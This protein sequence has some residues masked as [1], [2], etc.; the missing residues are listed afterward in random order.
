MTDRNDPAGRISA[1]EAE[2]ADLRETLQ[3]VQSIGLIG[4]VEVDLRRRA[5]RNFRSPEYLVIHGLPPDAA[6]ETHAQW[7][8][9]IHPDDRSRMEN[10]FLTEVSGRE[11]DYSAEYRIIRPSDREVRWI[12]AKGVIE[13]DPAG[14]PIRFVG[15]HLDITERRQLEQQTETIAREF[16]H[17][18][19]NL[20]SVVRSLVAMSARSHPEAAPF[21]EKVIGRIDALFRAKELVQPSR[22]DHT[23]SHTILDLVRTLLAPYAG[24]ENLIAIDGADVPVG[25]RASTALALGL[26]ELATNAVKY[27]ALSRERG[28]LSVVVA[29]LEGHVDVLWSETGGPAL[30]GKP[31]KSGFGFE[32]LDRIFTSQMK[33]TVVHEWLPDGVRVAIR[34]PVDRLAL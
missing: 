30:T 5:F 11:T 31:L 34:L 27:G 6:N 9:R 33:A 14:E 21:A 15:A 26:H 1:L 10:H 19:K 2:N 13:R 28:H 3:R 4:S 18:V 12:F 17:R 16:A 22:H 25:P 7:L 29:R 8:A 23:V 24:A 32:M 20:G